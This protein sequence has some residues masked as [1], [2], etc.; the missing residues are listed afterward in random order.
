MFLWTVFIYLFYYIKGY[1]KRTEF[2]FVILFFLILIF[3]LMGQIVL[4]WFEKLIL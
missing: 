2:L 4:I 3:T 1:V